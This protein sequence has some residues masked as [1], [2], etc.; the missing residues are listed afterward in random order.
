MKARSGAQGN[1]RA[2]ERELDAR[3]VIA[4]RAERARLEHQLAMTSGQISTL[5]S[6][7]ASSRAEVAALEY[8]TKTL[9]RKLQENEVR[10]EGL[11]DS[12]GHRATPE[13][14]D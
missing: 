11:R 12:N 10:A 2:A 7:I 8:E 13:D 6:Q 1:G 5:L 4:L 3:V 9:R 14:P